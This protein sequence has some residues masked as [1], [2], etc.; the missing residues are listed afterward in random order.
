MRRTAIAPSPTAEA[1]RLIDPLLMSP[2]ARTPGQLVSSR[3][4]PVAAGRS[5]PGRRGPPR[6]GPLGSCGRR[7][8]QDET[9]VVE[10]DGAPQPAGSR[11]GSD[12]D[13]EDV[14]VQ[15]PTLSGAVAPDDHRLQLTGFPD[16][17]LHLAAG[18][19][20][21]RRIPLDLVHEVARHVLTQIVRTNEEADPGGVL[22][23]E[24]GGLSGR[25]AAADDDD[26]A[27]R[28]QKAAS[29]NGGGVV[30]AGSLELLQPADVEPAVPRSGRENDAAGSNGCCRRRRRTV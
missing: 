22:C 29:M 7:P 21:D 28:A 23:Q 5:G 19:D 10:G 14:R 30:D 18:Q 15:P 8:G 3:P 13:E 9:L 17:L 24:H 2:T 6:L 26:R 11:H 20:L 25:V 16:E 27:G 4:S 1:T 12:E